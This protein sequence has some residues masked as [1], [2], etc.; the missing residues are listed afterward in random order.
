MSFFKRIFGKSSKAEKYV[1][2]SVI[3]GNSLTTPDPA[4]GNAL[5]FRMIIEDRFFLERDNHPCVVTGKIE[6]GTLQSGDKVVIVNKRNMH[7]EAEVV[8]IEQYRKMIAK[9][10]VGNHVGIRISSPTL[11]RGDNFY[12]YITTDDVLYELGSEPE[13]QSPHEA[14]PPTGIP[15]PPVSEIKT[16]TGTE[17]KVSQAP[18]ATVQQ[19]VAQAEK[20]IVEGKM[21]DGVELFRRALRYDPKVADTVYNTAFALHGGAAQRNQAASGNHLYFSG[22]FSE[23]DSAIAVMELLTDPPY[24]STDVWYQLGMFLD[25]RCQFDRAIA[26]YNRAIELEP[27]SPDACDALNNLGILYYNRGR[28]G[29]GIKDTSSGGVIVF[30][31]I[32]N[33]D[34]EKAEEAFLNVISVS[35]NAIARDPNCKSALI[36]SHRLLRD[37]YTHRLQGTKALEH[38]L[39]LYQQA[40]DDEDAV[41]WLRQAEKNTGKKLL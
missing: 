37:I 35:R 24:E 26:A 33:P 41:Q 20:A 23:L 12:S 1:Q 38:C 3:E 14:T 2:S 31:P 39:H 40:P 18:G 17:T 34:F 21:Q 13:K 7:L 27:E 36:N 29:L 8:A 30:D 11:T 15:A 16:E 5:P 19:L 4:S 32:N 10:T 25:H 22:G 28:G 6:S 9:A